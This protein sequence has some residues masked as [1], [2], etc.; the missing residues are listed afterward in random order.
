M[1]SIVDNLSYMQRV[2]CILRSYFPETLRSC[3]RIIKERAKSFN[4]FFS[5]KRTQYKFLIACILKKIVMNCSE[6]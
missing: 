5:F 4:K 1:Y 3:R 6:P 2:I